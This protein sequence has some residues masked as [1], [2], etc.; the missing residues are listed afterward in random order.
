MIRVVSAANCSARNFATIG[1]EGS[2]SDF[3]PKKAALMQLG[4]GE[5]GTFCL[6]NLEC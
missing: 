2:D 6:E 4:F 1:A 5:A 3:A